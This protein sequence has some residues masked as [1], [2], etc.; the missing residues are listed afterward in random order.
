MFHPNGQLAALEM[1]PDLNVDPCEI[2][3]S[4]Y[5]DVEGRLLPHRLEVELAERLVEV[6][7]THIDG[8]QFARLE[9]LDT[10]LFEYRDSLIG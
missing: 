2:Y 7:C 5:R 10:R 8:L 3:F 1:Y 6:T 9:L 4:Q